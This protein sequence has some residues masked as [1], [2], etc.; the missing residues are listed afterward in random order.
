MKRK[1]AKPLVIIIGSMVIITF[2]SQTLYYG[3]L[4]KVRTEV[5][6]GGILQHTISS[7]SFA[8]SSDNID[9]ICLPINISAT[10]LFVDKVDVAKAMMVDK[11]T[12]LMRFNIA[13]GEYAL[14]VAL[15]EYDQAKEALKTW[16][17]Q[18]TAEWRKL[19]REIYDAHKR[20]N[21]TGLDI[22]DLSIKLAALEEDRRV[23]EIEKTLNGVSRSSIEQVLET[24]RNKY[25]TLSS[26]SENQWVL[27]SPTEGMI[28]DTM[29]TSG[30]KYEGLV[31]LIKIVPKHAQIRVGIETKL[32][33][34]IVSMNDVFVYAGS[35]MPRDRETEWKFVEI[36][37]VGKNHTLWAEPDNSIEAVQHLE[38][39]T[40][41]VETEYFAYLVPNTAVIDGAL[42]ILDT[43]I[44]AFGK[45]ERF[46]RKIELR[47][48]T[49]DDKY[50]SVPIGLYGIED[51]I[52]EW[53]RPF[54]NGDTV[55]LPLE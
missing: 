17:K 15:T 30:D 19:D 3:T 16:D 20:I 46:A 9:Q 40:F 45:K 29:I 31:P 25:C 32:N 35:I 41:Q 49:S 52:V 28:I 43:R 14:K 6:I 42:F 5:P 12:I 4:P 24:V 38:R 7:S 51:V 2:I 50:T 26:L 33:P 55:T 47:G 18:F 8:L 37:T 1:A 22:N 10:P 39:L 44:G 21:D 48:H 11:G 23:L 36:S 13:V 27:L 53:D 54:Q 34:G